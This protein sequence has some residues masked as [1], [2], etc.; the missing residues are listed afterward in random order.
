[1]GAGGVS[2]VENSK[3]LRKFV[4]DVAGDV[5]STLTPEDKVEAVINVGKAKII[6]DSISRVDANGVWRLVI[7]LA[8]DG[9]APVEMNGFLKVGDN[10]ISEVWSYQWRRND[11]QW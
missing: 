1:S 9:D 11:G 3:D 10:R 2:G 8:P 5:F 6:H 7:D 4:L